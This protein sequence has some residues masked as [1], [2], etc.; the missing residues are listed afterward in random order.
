MY[1]IGQFSQLAKVTVKAL[2]YYDEVGLLKPAYVDQWTGYRSYGTEQLLPLQR[3]VA[4]RQA[5]LTIEEISAI[6]SGQDGAAVL[7]RRHRELKWELAE[8]KG[9]LDR[10]ESILHQ[11]D[12][13]MNYQATIRTIPGCTVFYKDGV[14]PTYAQLTDFILQA[15]AECIAANPGLKCAEPDYSFVTYEADSFQEKDIS[16][17]YAQAVVSKGVETDAIKFKELESVEAVCVYHKGD[18]AKLGEAYAFAMNWLKENGY[19]LAQPPRE[20]YIDGCW[21]KEC[22]A[23]Y[24]TELQFPVK[25]K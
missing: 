16:L 22:V 18:W 9:R 6:L 23:D 2:R 4:L 14:V 8:A 7:E 21:N 24:L 20:R 17:C 19:E 11:E 25:K 10:L 15:G 3:I 1:R 13:L 12:F 5:G